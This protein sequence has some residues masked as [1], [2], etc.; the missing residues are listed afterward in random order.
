MDGLLRPALD[1]LMVSGGKGREP[2][3]VEDAA[4]YRNQGSGLVV[5]VIRS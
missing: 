4:P 5:V 2:L 3:S 1:Q